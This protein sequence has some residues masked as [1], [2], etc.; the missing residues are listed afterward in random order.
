LL[1][2]TTRNR[3]SACPVTREQV[4]VPV[5]PCFPCGSTA[6]QE[7][8]PAVFPS[9]A[10][11]PAFVH[12]PGRGTLSLQVAPM[13]RLCPARLLVLAVCRIVRFRVQLRLVYSFSYRRCFGLW[14]FSIPPRHLVRQVFDKIPVRGLASVSSTGVFSASL[15]HR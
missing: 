14:K 12:A 7:H 10:A 8:P 1:P 9:P 3:S 4:P 15:L 5:R 6:D 11:R 2:R 13:L